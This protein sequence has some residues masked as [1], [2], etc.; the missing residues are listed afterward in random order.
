MTS[1]DD[2]RQ[3]VTVPPSGA[4]GGVSRSPRRRCRWRPFRAGAAPGSENPA[5]AIPELA[6]SPTGVGVLSPGH[7]GRPGTRGRVLRRV[8]SPRLPRQRQDWCDKHLRACV[9]CGRVWRR[10]R[11]RTCPDCGSELSIC[12]TCDRAWPEDKIRKCRYPV[13]EL[14]RLVKSCAGDWE[15]ARRALAAAGGAL[16]RAWVMVERRRPQEER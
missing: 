3:V 9:A 1:A 4:G 8:P 16:A 10:R 13:E 14:R 12:L 5:P 7:R 11:R 15:W 6:G 2:T